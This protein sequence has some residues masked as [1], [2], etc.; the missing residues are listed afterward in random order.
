MRLDRFISNHTPLSRKQAHQAIKVG[1]IQLDGVTAHS[2][3]QKLAGISA[4]TLDDKEICAPKAQYLMLNKPQ[5]VVSAT[6]D[7][8]HP[9]V[10]DL[11]P[12]NVT[13]QHK[14]QIVGRLDIDTTGLVLLTTDGQWN[15]CITSPNRTCTKT[16]TVSLAAPLNIGNINQLESGILLNGESKITRPC[17]IE[18]ITNTEANITLVEGKY[19]QVKRMFAAIDNKVLA[20]HRW[21]VGPIELPPQLPPGEYCPIPPNKVEAV[22]QTP[23]A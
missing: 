2:G 10:L 6:T 7:S 19:H 4:V 3:A 22:W 13:A 12:A 11:I 9:T 18:L 17:K 16:Y 8:M 20:L 14:L 5:G 1:R 23:T 15:H 21:R